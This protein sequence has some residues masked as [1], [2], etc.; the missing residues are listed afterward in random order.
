VHIF[1][2]SIIKDFL[3]PVD[4]KMTKIQACRF[5]KFNF[6][7]LIG[8][9]FLPFVINFSAE[10]SV[11]LEENGLENR[12]EKNDNLQATADALLRFFDRMPTVPIFISDA[13]KLKSGTN[14]ERGVAYTECKDHEVPVIFMKKSFFEAANQKQLEN[15]LKH[16]LTHSWLCRQKLMA[17]HDAR[18]RQKFAAIGGFGN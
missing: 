18:F 1:F 16:E 6:A 13:P 12:F 5:V 7:A 9:L 4:R 10:H 8:L 15:I 2:F 3:I 11:S 17:G 14:T